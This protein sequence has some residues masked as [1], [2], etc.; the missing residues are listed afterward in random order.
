MSV[1][2]VVVEM[3]TAFIPVVHSMTETA[4]SKKLSNV[5]VVSPG[6][7]QTFSLT[8]VDPFEEHAAAELLVWK[9]QQRWF[10]GD[11]SGC[12]TAVRRS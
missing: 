6:A 1:S 12:V 10:D 7:P 5:M 11:C 2:S 3:P 4:V 9:F 8:T